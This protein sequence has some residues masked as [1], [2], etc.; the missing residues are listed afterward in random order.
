MMEA[1][2][3]KFM[4]RCL[5][6][7]QKAE[8]LTYPNPM[9]GSVI[10][11]E[12]KIIGEGY[13]LRAGESH[14]EVNAVNSVSDKS[15]LKA[16]TLYVNLEPCSHFG[17]TP[18][19][20]DF[21][22]SNGIP[23]V[24]IG[25]AD[26]SEK[27]SGKGIERLKSAGCEV[28]TGVI[29][30]ECRRLNRRFFTFNEKKRPYITLK[31]ARSADGYLDV[32]RTS[33]HKAEPTWIS[34]KPERILVHKWRAS[35]QSILV[36]AGTI[37]ADDPQLNVREWKGPDPLKLILSSSGIV[38]AGSALNKSNRVILFT[39]NPTAENPV[40]ERVIIN[41]SEASSVQI[42]RY[43]YSAGLQS[44]FIEGGAEVLNHFIST[45]LWDEA[46][47]FTGAD[48][49]REGPKAP[50]VKG[51]LFSGTVFSGSTLEIYLKN[52]S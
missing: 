15:K 16:S 29:E 9:V 23:K 20:A 46:R 2:D 34:G 10:V 13:H 26:S 17:K 33:D 14:A 27:V 42:A 35:E 24:V 51:T 12:G 7:A 11:H 4:H 39:H 18:P 1:E 8:G 21:I 32:L 43:L 37:R 5:E 25:T 3:I 22:V 45:G 41:R 28:I 38:N 36:G 52:G 6:L 49:F 50:S 19:C 47:I 48:Y 44:L 40:K 30:E 31:W